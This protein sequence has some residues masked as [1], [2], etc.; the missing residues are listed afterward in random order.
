MGDAADRARAL[1]AVKNALAAT[2]PTVPVGT[3]STW[4]QK[5]AERTAEP[6]LLM[7]ILSIFALLAALLAAAGVYGL[8]SW[9]VTMR[10][11]EL[12]IRQ[13]LGA[14]PV[15]VGRLVLGQSALLVVLGLGVGLVIVRVADRALQT[16]LY[17]V[18]ATD[19]AALLAAST[20]L[21]AAAALA[22][23]PALLRAM[24]VDP[25]EGLRVE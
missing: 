14:S 16:V 5:L 24:R 4:G 8:V 10:Q 15:R 9:S 18:R 17:Q 6:R 25:A 13:V 23:A 3:A 21:L 12:A 19:P 1:D 2:A 11:R 20:V 7:R 22:C